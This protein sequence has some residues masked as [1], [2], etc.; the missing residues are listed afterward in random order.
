MI[1]GGD[2][3]SRSL[4]FRRIYSWS[5]VSNLINI[6]P[7][8]DVNNQDGD[9][10]DGDDNNSDND[11][12]TPLLPQHELEYEESSSSSS[13]IEDNDDHSRQKSCS[14]T[15]IETNWKLLIV[16]TLL[17]L[18]GVGNVIFAKLQALPM[19]NY[20]T[21]LN[22]YANGMYVLMSFTYILPVSMLGLFKNS[23][24]LALPPVSIMKPFFIMGCLDAVSATLQVLST[25]YLPGT[26]LVLIPQVAIPLSMAAGSLILREK[27]T[28]RQY[29]GAV[30][31]FCGILVVLYPI[32]THQRDAD[33]YCKAIDT[34][35]DCVICDIATSK[36]ECLSYAQDVN[37]DNNDNHNFTQQQFT[38]TNIIAD[39]Y[40][41]D[42]G[43]NYY[44]VWV[45]TEETTA[46]DDDFL[47][48]FWS[49]VMILSFVP[50]VMST[51]YKQVALQTASTL[52]PILINGWVSLF[53]FL[54]GLFLV[55]PSG[56]V[57]SP[58][59]HPLEIP[60]NWLD[61][62]GCLFEQTNSIESGCHPDDCSKSFLWVHLSLLNSAVYV[63]SMLFV[64]KYGSCDLMYLGLTLVVPL[65]HLAFSF[66]SSFSELR[67]FD[68]VGLIILISG[69]VLYRFGH[70]GKRNHDFDN[71][72][73]YH[74]YETVEGGDIDVVSGTNSNIN[75]SSSLIRQTNQNGFLEFLREPFMLIGDI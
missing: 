30:I 68:I 66:H 57:S 44:C 59:V 38:T 49:I 69:L 13:V 18:S 53:Q 71:N 16:F 12:S 55:I 27:Y 6:A 33:Y 1:P 75:T 64:L 45:S 73:Y 54:C 50:S 24:P 37:D 36:H 70:I 4:L 14:S 2:H 52:D 29:A 32:L 8:Y 3:S 62:V 48:F 51:V 61:G 72:Q 63:L 65:S 58:K 23:I 22:I 9:G 39:G 28:I 7:M 17:V 20:P 5:E 19:Y 42:D 34:D 60:S 40:N 31:M 46:R 25:V 74:Q 21:F 67:V 47:V 41:N 11:L 35:N 43:S 15:I 10:I 56:L 26:L